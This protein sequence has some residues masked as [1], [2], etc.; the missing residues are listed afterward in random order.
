MRILRVK[1]N[2]CKVQTE[3]C[4][5]RKAGPANDVTAALYGR[6]GGL[7]SS[8]SI[9]NT[10]LPGVAMAALIIQ[11]GGTLGVLRQLHRLINPRSIKS[12]SGARRLF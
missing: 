8:P 7:V 4:L 2:N 3:T 9:A 11:D 12:S 6:C 5:H 1:E 10:R